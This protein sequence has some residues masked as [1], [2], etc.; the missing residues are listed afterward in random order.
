MDR[1]RLIAV[2]AAVTL[3]ITGI[4]VGVWHGRHHD[5]TPRH[6]PTT[7]VTTRRAATPT[8]T[9]TPAMSVQDATR[10]AI[11]FEH[12]ARDWGADPNA[13]VTDNATL[14][15]LRTPE[16]LDRTAFN[17]VASLPAAQVNADS[18]SAVCAEDPTAATCKAHPT[19]LSYW[20]ANWYELG[21]RLDGEPTS[22]VNED[23]T[24]T[25]TGKL[26]L[27]A[28]ANADNAATVP[29]YWGYSP[30]TW[31]LT[32]TDTLTI[33]NGK[34]TAWR[35]S[36]PGWLAAPMTGDWSADPLAQIPSDST[37]TDTPVAG[38]LPD[39]GLDPDPGLAVMAN[40]TDTTGTAWA[41]ILAKV[42]PG[43]P[44]EQGNEQSDSQRL[45]EQD[46]ERLF[47]G[48]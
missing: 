28:W 1:K 11:A 5:T 37:Q 3:I 13:T 48:D 9:R 32:Y 40:S 38:D 35:T 41:D 26:R 31:S 15:T 34:V 43:Q 6:T 20:R 2:I 12:A 19:R 39:L 4:G 45:S 24:L 8:P 27:V 22:Q 21:A 25:V 33:R 10:L 18:P 23:G 14:A 36:Q 47:G 44:D 42:A 30:R 17:Q 7:A 46:Y 29:G 16:T